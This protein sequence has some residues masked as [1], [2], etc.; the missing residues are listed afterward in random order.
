MHIT[1]K[2]LVDSTDK[3]VQLYLKAVLYPILFEVCSCIH[4]ITHLVQ[5]L[6]LRHKG[7]LMPKK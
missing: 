4:I 3:S 1:Y 2:R 5:A 7:Y 6:K